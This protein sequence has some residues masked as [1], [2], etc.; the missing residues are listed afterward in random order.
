[1]DTGAWENGALRTTVR[2]KLSPL[3]FERTIELEEDEVRLCY[4]LSNWSAAEEFYLWAMHPLLHLQA[5]DQL[6]LPGSTRAL[7]NGIAW[8][9]AVNA[10]HLK[11]NGNGDKV[12]ASPLSE[13]FA[14][15]QNQATG[16]RLEFEWNPSENGTL[17]IWLTRGGWHGHH[18]FALEPANGEPDALTT[19]VQRKSCGVVSARS[20][21]SWQII[22]RVGVPSGDS[23]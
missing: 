21:V 7:L 5:G 4:Q 18:H 8:L 10:A 16:D 23:G 22:L 17:G 2:L 3:D 12:F 1:V 15:I 14:A 6:K 13:G 11:L 9:D 19:A 20:S